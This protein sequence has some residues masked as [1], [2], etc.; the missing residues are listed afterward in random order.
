[1]A[2]LSFKEPKNTKEFYWTN[3][4]KRK[5]RYYG[6]GEGRLK[7]ILKTPQRKEEGIA[8]ET[9][10]VMQSAGTKKPTEIWL[11]YQLALRSASRQGGL[12]GK[13]KKMISAWRYPGVSPKGKEIPIPEDILEELKR[14]KIFDKF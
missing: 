1:M 11:M 5:M 8:P 6:L 14:E 9:I 3:H 4:I 7:R 13:K 10:A 12:V 2:L